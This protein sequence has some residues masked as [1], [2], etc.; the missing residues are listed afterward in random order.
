MI[1]STWIHKQINIEYVSLH[2]RIKNFLAFNRSFYPPFEHGGFYLT[3]TFCFDWRWIIHE[4][5]G[6][7]ANFDTITEEVEQYFSDLLN[8]MK[9]G[10]D[11]A[12]QKES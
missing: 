9:I 5:V 2:L 7:E 6:A 8:S 11:K 12:I 1:L 3:S 10:I 4:I